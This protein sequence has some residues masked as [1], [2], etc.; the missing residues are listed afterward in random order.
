MWAFESTFYQIYPIGFCGAPLHNDGIQEHRIKRVAEW[1][2]Y[3]EELG[4]GAV[5]L[6]PVFESSAHG[7]DTRDFTKID[8]RLGTNDDFVEVVRELHD[9]GI[10]VV[11]DAVFN[12]V[13]R[14]FWAFQ[15]VRE[16][17]WDSPYRDWFF[18]NFEGDSAF[19]DGFWYEGWEGCSDLVKLNLRNP[20][21]VE[22][23]LDIV[24]AWRYEFDIDG[25]RLDV[26][27]SLDHDFIRRLRQVANDITAASEPGR[28]FVLIGETLHGDY[29][30]IVND[31]MLHSCTNYECYKGLYSSFNSQNMFE[32]AHS[33]HRQFGGDPWCIYRG[34][35][36]L[37][38]ADNHDVT[39]LASILTEPRAIRPAYGVL[40]GMPGIP[41]L[42]YGSEWGQAGV[43]GAHDDYDL[44]P[45]FVEPEPNELTEYLKGLIAA[46]ADSRALNYGS[47][48]N[49]VITNKQLL[50]ERAVDMDGEH[51][52][53]RV[54]V[55][56]NAV[57]EP[58]TLQADELRGSFADL[59]DRGAAPVELDGSLELAPFEVR[60][61]RS[62]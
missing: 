57:D 20:A 8:C 32:I 41:C 31:G 9:H 62:L 26:A 58:F 7:Y 47:Y 13:G 10:R 59:L 35:H 49:V 2:D 28:D 45:E 43:K 33:L 29:S 36:L 61:L 19:G 55:A 39:R 15:D 17:R 51:P 53:E 24:R 60:W 37:S 52:S 23:L 3:L 56:V 54:L 40:F 34:L 6:N 44:R 30:Q 12:H 16:K 11:L 5:L 25:L 50:F 21:V 1:A 38:F 22:Y 18:I 27:Y 42:Y 4:V 48:R 14:E 46:R